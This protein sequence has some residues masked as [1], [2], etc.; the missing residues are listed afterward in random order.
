[1]NQ[2]R[3]RISDAVRRGFSLIEA[4]TSTTLVA[5]LM[6]GATNM[7]GSVV[8]NRTSNSDRVRGLHLAQQLM[9]EISSADYREPG[10]GGLLDGVLAVLGVESGEGGGTRANFDDVDD[11][12]NW[13]AS[14]PQDRFGAAIDNTTGWRHTVV[15][16]PVD[17][18]NPA[19][20]VSSDEGLKRVTISI[21]RGGA[22]VTRLVGLRTD[23]YSP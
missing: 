23:R 3:R 7:L 1:M 17:P 21:Y 5:V 4:V 6:L 20:V 18:T 13:T 9:A 2:S 22:L 19:A 16:E 12:H 8:K 14:P 15:V 10:D 11:Y